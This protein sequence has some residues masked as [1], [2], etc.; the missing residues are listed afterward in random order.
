MSLD[1]KDVLCSNN[2]NWTTMQSLHI[3][4]KS[5]AR[6]HEAACILTHQV[7]FP[8]L[9]IIRACRCQWLNRVTQMHVHACLVTQSK[10]KQSLSCQLPA[11]TALCTQ[12]SQRSG[13]GSHL[14]KI[15]KQCCRS[16]Q[17]SADLR[18]RMS[19]E[20]GFIFGSKGYVAGIPTSPSTADC[21]RRLRA[22]LTHR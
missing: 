20:E 4:I 12:L 18:T 17:L 13:S 16:S 9:G 1:A 19:S 5:Q 7:L 8:F 15:Q 21:G 2:L 6:P 22:C 10:V 3:S 14:L 11:Y